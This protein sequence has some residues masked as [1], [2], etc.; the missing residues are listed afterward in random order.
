MTTT[1]QTMHDLM[2]FLGAAI[3]DDPEQ[4]AE[5]LSNAMFAGSQY[6]M[7]AELP[8][9]RGR[10]IEGADLVVGVNVEGSRGGDATF[11]DFVSFPITLIA[12]EDTLN[13]VEEKAADCL[14]EWEAETPEKTDDWPEGAYLTPNDRDLPYEFQADDDPHPSI[15]I[16]GESEYDEAEAAEQDRIGAG[17]FND[18]D[19]RI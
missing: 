11:K 2:R 10:R 8:D 12:W 17:S 18:L 19:H 3:T 13:A 15:V 6:R 7:W 1:F 5:A 16:D 14:A 4:D 9:E